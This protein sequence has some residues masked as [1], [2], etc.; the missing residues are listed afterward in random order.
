MDA[1]VFGKMFPPKIRADV[2]QFHDIERTFTLMRK[3]R[4]VRGQPGE[5]EFDGHYRFGGLEPCVGLITRMPVQNSRATFQF[6]DPSIIHFFEH[7]Q[8]RILVADESFD[9]IAATIR[10]IDIEQQDSQFRV[11]RNHAGRFAEVERRNGA[12]VNQGDRCE[13]RRRCEFSSTLSNP[14]ITLN[15]AA[16]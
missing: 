4:G 9:Q 5:S 3:T 7:E 16:Y 12:K 8:V 15:N 2:H 11:R 6:I 10:R 1:R 14:A 13:H